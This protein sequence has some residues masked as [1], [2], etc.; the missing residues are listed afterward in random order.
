MIKKA[1]LDGRRYH[2]VVTQ[3]RKKQKTLEGVRPI[4]PQTKT[5]TPKKKKKKKKKTT[6]NPQDQ[7]KNQQGKKKNPKNKKTSF[8]HSRGDCSLSQQSAR[9]VNVITN[10]T[11]R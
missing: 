1:S 6:Q 3:C 9:L 7:Q 4:R 8:K 2:G 10:S 5:K 11:L